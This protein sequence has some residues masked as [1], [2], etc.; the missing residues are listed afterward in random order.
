M[1]EQRIINLVVLV[2][3]LSGSFAAIF[4]LSYRMLH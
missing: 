4:Y 2:L 1:G 3:V